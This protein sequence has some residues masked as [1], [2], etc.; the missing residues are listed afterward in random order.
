MK[1]T[2]EELK[3]VKFPDCVDRCLLVEVL[4][5]GECENIE[6]CTDKVPRYEKEKV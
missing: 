1:K 6:F 5:I 2:A 3:D 4:G